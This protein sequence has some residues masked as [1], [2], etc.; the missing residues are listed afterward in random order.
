M[1]FPPVDPAQAIAADLPIV[2]YMKI[3]TFLML[4]QRE[5]FIP[6]LKALQ[7]TDPLEALLPGRTY[8]PYIDAHEALHRGEVYRWLFS[9]LQN[10]ERDYIDQDE[11]NL[12][13][14]GPILLRTWLEQLA[15]RR[16]IWC[17]YANR[18]ES[19]S[20]WNNYGLQGVAIV[21]TVARVRA[22]LSLPNDALTSVAKV[23][24]VDSEDIHMDPRLIEPLWI[25]RPYYFKQ[26]AY[27]YEKE[28]RFVL[29]AEPVYL[30]LRG[31]IVRKVEPSLLLDEV[32]ISPHIPFEEAKAIEHTIRAVCPFLGR[33]QVTIS[34]L[35][36]PG[37]PAFREKNY[38]RT[39]NVYDQLELPDLLS[40]L[41]QEADGEGVLHAL[42]QMM[43][44]V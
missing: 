6:S 16:S 23:N 29:A 20:M 10:W 40:G 19:M 28:V 2:R 36:F 11:G 26:K 8:A 21:S 34:P 7:R 22:A 37:D 35:L 12:E 4:T 24:Y 41:E 17:W 18:P 32:L 14:F 30:G 39:R 1:H 13:R 25:N 33:Q 43:L 42:P 5:V 27:E 9:K 31:G 3:G 44:E 15:I 38:E